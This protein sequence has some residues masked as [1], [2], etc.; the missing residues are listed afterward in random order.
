[1]IE[2]KETIL[3][4][5][6]DPMNLS[7]LNDYFAASGFRVLVAEDGESAVQ[8][9]A[10]LKP[11]IILLDIKLPGIDGFEVCRRLKGDEKAKDSPILFMTVIAEIAEK[12]K[13]F[14]LG[15]VDYITK[16]IDLEEVAARVN[17]HLTIRRLQKKFEEQNLKLQRGEER[18]KHLLESISDGVYV[19]DRDWRYTL[20]NENA[21]RLVHMSPRDLLGKKITALFPGIEESKFFKTYLD[22]I[23]TGQPGAVVN[24]FNFPDGP[25]GW[26]EVR[27]YPVPEGILCIAADITAHHL[28]REKIK[29]SLVEKEVLL[30]EI[31]HR[32]KNNLQ[33]INSLLSL[34]SRR[35]DDKKSAAVLMEVNNRIH[36]IALIHEKLYQAEDLARIDFDEYIRSL[37]GHL[38]SASPELAPGVRFKIKAGEILFEIGKA[39]PCALI[40]NELVT[41]SLKYAFPRQRDGEIAIDLSV[42]AGDKAILSVA[43]NGIGLPVDFSIEEAGTLGIQIVKALVK[44]LHGTL[45]IEKSKGSKFTIE[46]PVK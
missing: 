26:Y 28:A 10:D 43:D 36:S 18:Y 20:V 23:R 4:V 34:H 19:L 2:K 13:A 7:L 11:D 14:A 29:A 12:V 5:D 46:F 27:V 25:R 45:K 8:R 37:T 16:P 38:R 9:A 35:V 24:E 21:A 41:N 40:I 15:A 39:I 33:L 3:I 31:H 32:V 1:M 42:V 44:Q 22:V 6:D 17:T 30:K